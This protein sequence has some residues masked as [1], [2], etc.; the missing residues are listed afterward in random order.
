MDA[1]PEVDDAKAA[2]ALLLDASRITYFDRRY[3]RLLRV[4]RDELPVLPFDKNKRRGKK[5][6]HKVKNFHD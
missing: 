1:K 2:G 3:S 4:G 5:K 6:Q